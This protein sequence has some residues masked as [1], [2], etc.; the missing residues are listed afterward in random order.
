MAMQV[1]PSQ[2][3][4]IT[5]RIRAIVTQ[6]EY[7]ILEN[8]YILVLDTKVVVLL[9]EIILREVLKS[10]GR[11]IG[12]DNVVCLSLNENRKPTSESPE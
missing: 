9:G 8:V 2:A 3:S 11:I 6:Q 7:S 1:W 4:N 12:E 5:F 10:L